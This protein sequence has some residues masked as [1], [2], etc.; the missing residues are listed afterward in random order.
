MLNAREAVMTID[1]PEPTADGG[2]HH[3]GS[4]D[5][6]FQIPGA[7]KDQMNVTTPGPESTSTSA[8]TS[9]ADGRQGQNEH[10]DS[11]DEIEDQVS[12]SEWKKKGNVFFGKEDWDRA[13]HAYHSGLT[14]FLK[15]QRLAL[16]EES[17]GENVAESQLPS[18]SATAAVESISGS[19]SASVAN[20]LEV[21]L[22]SNMA[23]VLLKLQQYD[24]AEEECNQLLAISPINSKGTMLPIV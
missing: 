8:L 19:A 24:R 17:N 18:K 6:D 13:L 1:T 3:N 12:P 11:Q 7:S 4:D 15:E 10:N 16:E 14:A 22:R 23:F 5:G 21:A 9:T 2:E 20:P